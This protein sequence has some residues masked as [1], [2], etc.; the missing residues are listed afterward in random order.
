MGRIR[1]CRGM[2]PLATHQLD[3]V[4]TTRRT[5]GGRFFKNP[6]HFQIALGWGIGTLSIHIPPRI[7]N[8]T[9]GAARRADPLSPKTSRRAAE[10]L[11]KKRRGHGCLDREKHWPANEAQT[12]NSRPDGGNFA[13][14]SENIPAN[15]NWRADRRVGPNFRRECAVPPK[16]SLT[17]SRKATKSR[18]PR[19]E[20]PR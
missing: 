2:R 11:R 6:Y 1:V 17:R 18:S 10:T 5:R 4:E 20:N 13:R 15:K 8:Q 7:E 16:S 3:S 19:I 14:E 9:V 12:G